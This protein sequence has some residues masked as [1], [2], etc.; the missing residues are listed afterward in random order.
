MPV[1]NSPSLLIVD[2]CGT[3]I[4]ENT[5]N[6]FLDR[7]LLKQGWRHTLRRLLG[8][9]RPVSVLALRGIPK[10]HLYE[11]A[12]LYVENRLSTLFNPA[13]LDAIRQAQRRGTPVYLATASLDPIAAAVAKQLRLN[14]VV[15]SRLGYDR[16][17][18]CT[19]LFAS[20]VTGRKLQHLRRI[21]PENLLRNATVYT[22]NREDLDLLRICAAPHFLGRRPAL[23]RLSDG[24]LAR[25]QFLG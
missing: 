25:I 24:E 3:I 21:I 16:R 6:A 13:P 1:Q 8:G 5:T 9:K 23:S 17:G 22:D 12:E 7:W 20:D 2:L 15:C 14:G 18:R 11:Q 4:V 10:A 19:G